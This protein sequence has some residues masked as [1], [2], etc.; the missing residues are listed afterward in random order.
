[1]CSGVKAPMSSLA[2][3]RNNAVIAESVDA[4]VQAGML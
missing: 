4:A 3:E 2:A 1:M